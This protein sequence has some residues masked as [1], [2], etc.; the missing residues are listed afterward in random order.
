L[1]L[2][3]WES[4]DL[5]ADFVWKTVHKKFYDR[6]AEWYDAQ[7]GPRLVMW[8]VKAGHRPDFFEA[9]EKY[10]QFSKYGATDA[11]F[12]WDHID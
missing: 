6:R 10:R 3:V 1:T 7:D 8:W 5:L 4:R 11:A 12:G 2:S 9:M